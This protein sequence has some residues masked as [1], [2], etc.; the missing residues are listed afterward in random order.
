VQE[1][2][3]ATLDLLAPQDPQDLL[4]AKESPVSQDYLEARDAQDAQV[5]YHHLPT[6]KIASAATALLDPV[7]L[8]DQ[9]GQLDLLDQWDPLD[10]LASA[11]AMVAQDPQDLLEP[12][13]SQDNLVAQVEQE[14]QDK[15]EPEE[16]KEAQDPRDPVD[17][18][19]PR[20]PADAQEAWDSQ[21][22]QE[23][24]DPPDPQGDQVPQDSLDSQEAQAHLPILESMPITAHAHVAQRNKSRLFKKENDFY[25]RHWYF[26][27]DNL[28]SYEYTRLIRAQ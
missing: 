25:S 17:N 10:H 22:T 19:D 23:D 6:T 14:P 1:S 11:E 28:H 4:V 9:L 20:D 24:R 2:A 27:C 13:A 16:A 15:M 26:V 21:E 18:Q 5:P 12:E 8:P 3:S 7:D